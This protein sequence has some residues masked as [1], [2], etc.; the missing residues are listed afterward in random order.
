MK[1]KNVCLDGL[2]LCNEALSQ[3]SEEDSGRRAAP[4]AGLKSALIE[5]HTAISNLE[6]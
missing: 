6:T 3:L 5:A 1:K 2:L 4:S